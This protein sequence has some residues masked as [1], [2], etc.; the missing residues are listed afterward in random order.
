[1]ERKRL[2]VSPHLDDSG[3]SFGGTLLT[4][5]SK[6]KADA[7][8]LMVTTFARSRYTRDGFGDA[9]AV[10]AQRQA[11]EKAVMGSVGADTLFINLPECSLRGYTISNPLDYPMEIDPELDPDIVDVMSQQFDLLFARFDEILVPLAIDQ[12]AHVDHRIVREAA[13][14]AWSRN[15]NL[16]FRLYEDVPYIGQVSRD[17]V[18]AINGMQ[19]REIRIDLK[20]KLKLIR[21]YKSQPV[22]SWEDLISEAAGQPPVERTW[23]VEKPSVLNDLEPGRL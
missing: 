1:M 20:A 9:I 6:R 12:Q 14:A 4:C 22:E 18:S 21:G 15:P 5:L 23:L 7:P 13:S 2:F 3:I 10:T 16:I 11:E 17:R 8:P 19:F